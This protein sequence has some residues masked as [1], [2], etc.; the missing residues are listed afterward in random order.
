MTD[1]KKKVLIIDDDPMICETV[2]LALVHEGYDA[3]ALAKPEEAFARV[4]SERPDLV[5][6]DLYM[7]DVNG[8]DICRKLKA[9]PELKRI[10]VMIFTGSN[11]T[12]DVIAGID[13]GAFE[14]ITKPV[15]GAVLIKK[16]KE[17]LR[18]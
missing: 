7:P 8:W 1:A 2:R 6:L 18:A 11:E 3:K 12:V 14:Y 15:D 9:D 17:K 4:Q 10:P 16:I 13:A 5:I